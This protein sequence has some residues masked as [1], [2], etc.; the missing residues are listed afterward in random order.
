MTAQ[1]MESLVFKGERLR[2][3]TTPL[4]IYLT[5]SGIKFYSEST[6]NWRGYDGFWEIKGSEELGYRL[7]LVSLSASIAYQKRVGLDYLFPDYPNGVFAHWFTGEIRCPRGDRLRYV[8]GGYAS[9]Y[10]EDLFL[11]IQEGVLKGTRV[12]KNQA[13]TP[14]AQE[15]LP[16][17]LRS[18]GKNE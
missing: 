9:I 14:I 12:I 6:A 16:W 17:F 15:D 5:Q 7:Y 4:D 3:C 10:E 13:P 11:E 1:S 8:H 18:G 2:M